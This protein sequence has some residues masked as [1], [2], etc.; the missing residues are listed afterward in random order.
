MKFRWLVC[1]TWLAPVMAVVAASMVSLLP[2]CEDGTDDVE[3]FFNN[4]AV[5]TSGRS[6]STNSPY[7]APVSITLDTDGMQAVFTAYEGRGPYEWSVSDGRRGAIRV[8]GD[9][10][11]LYT[12]LSKG[13]NSVVVHDQQGHWAVATVNQPADDTTNT[14]VTTASG[15]HASGESGEKIR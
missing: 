12:R 4:D 2:G 14:T 9:S 15:E 3:N 6:V 7:I 10:Q 13:N 11:A 1:P 5:D 8:D